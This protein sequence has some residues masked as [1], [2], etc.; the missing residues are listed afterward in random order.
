MLSKLVKDSHVYKFITHDVLFGS[1]FDKYYAEEDE[2][3]GD[4]DAEA[5]EGIIPYVNSVLAE[6]ISEALLGKPIDGRFGRN[7]RADVQDAIQ[8]IGYVSFASYWLLDS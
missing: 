6:L 2:I 1:A 4:A 5:V 8:D 3:G 7:L